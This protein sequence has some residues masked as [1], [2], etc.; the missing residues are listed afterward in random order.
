MDAKFPSLPNPCQQ[1]FYRSS[2]EVHLDTFSTPSPRPSGER[3]GV[4]GFEPKNQRPSFLRGGEGENK[5]S[6]KMHPEHG[7]NLHFHQKWYG[8]SVWAMTSEKGST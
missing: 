7:V 2:T 4:R 3:V 6:V 1:F 5:D 8:P